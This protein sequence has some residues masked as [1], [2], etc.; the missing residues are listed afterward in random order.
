MKKCKTIKEQPYSIFHINEIY[1]YKIIEY[2][3]LYNHFIYDF[4]G[5]NLAQFSEV[6]FNINFVDIIEDRKQKLKRINAKS[7]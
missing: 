7:V 5:K 3:G 6:Y 4:N 1:K 2:V